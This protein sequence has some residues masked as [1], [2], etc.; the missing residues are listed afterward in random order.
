MTTPK[1]YGAISAVMAQMAKDGISKDR[2]N[3]QQGYAFRGIDDIYN[4]LS[5]VLSAN[6][7]VMLPFVQDMQREERATKNGGVINYTILTVDFKLV[8]AE[9]GSNDTIRTI[10]EAMDSADKSANKAQSAALK[11]A[12]L[13]VFMIPTEGDNDADAHTHEVAAREGPAPR[14][15]LEGKHA[16]K[17]KLQEAL[18]TLGAKIGK[19]VTPKQLMDLMAEYQDDIEQG[20]R[21]LPMWIDGD[22]ENPDKRGLQVLYN[23]RKGLIDL[24]EDMKTSDSRRALTIWVG[25]NGD[26]VDGLG[27]GDRRIFEEQYA[28]YESGLEQAENLRA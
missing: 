28:A 1:V 7:L 6:K 27:D 8:S 14:E 3:Q 15:K 25:Q 13:Q 22:P 5:S 20:K 16:S 23:E 18:R 17:S 11:Y 26:L 4:A 24:I 21:Y 19:A 2:K 10:G 12:A 9:D